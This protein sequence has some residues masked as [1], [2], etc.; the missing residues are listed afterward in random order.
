MM[1]MPESKRVR[2]ARRIL[3]YEKEL[4]A[5]VRKQL[6]RVEPGLVEA[7]DG[8]EREVP[9]GK[10]DITARDANGNLMVIELKA[11]PCPVGALEQVLGYT[12]DLEAETGAPC[13]AVLIASEFSDRI[14][15]AAKRANEVYLVT[16]Q[17]ED[18][19]FAESPPPPHRMPNGRAAHPQAPPS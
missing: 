18:V 2:T 17:M 16:Y 14:R 8:R 5:L 10:I 15:A 11:G 19:G 13:R 1:P 4:K 6:E 9:T 7:D 12:A 3:H